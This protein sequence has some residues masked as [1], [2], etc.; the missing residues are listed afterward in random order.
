MNRQ[1]Q[2]VIFDL[3]GVIADTNDYYNRANRKLAELW[4]T[5]ISEE[6]NESFKGIHRSVIVKAIAAKAGK[7]LTEEEIVHYG[8][9]KNAFYQQQITELSPQ[10][11]LPGIEAFLQEL[12][13]AGILIAL[14]SSSSNYRFVLERLGVAGY[15]HVAVDPAYIRRMKPAPDIFE[16]AAELLGVV[17]ENCAAI[18]DGEA[19][20]AAIRATPMFAVAI[21]NA[22]FHAAADWQLPNTRGLGLTELRRRFEEFSLIFPSKIV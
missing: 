20:L 2:A 7:T 11:V 6:E 19:G 14:A 21:G 10:D 9:M 13:Q 15:F 8:A 3:D 12:R 16:R 1:L 5:T 22:P 17:P 18:E 4:G